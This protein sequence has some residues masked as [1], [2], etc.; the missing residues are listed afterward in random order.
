MTEAVLER[1]EKTKDTRIC[2]ISGPEFNGVQ[3]S[4]DRQNASTPH[5]TKLLM[6]HGIGRH[7]AGYSARFRDKL[8]QSLELD[9]MD[10]TIKKIALTDAPANG[11]ATGIL[12]IYR[13][14]SQQTGR[15]LLFYE[16]TWSGITDDEKDVVAFDNSEAYT[17]RRADINKSLKQFLNNTVP[18][19][20]VY[21][22]NKK[23]LIDQS[24]SQSVCWMFSDGWEKLPE[25]GSHHCNFY[26]NSIADTVINDDFFVVTHSM[27]SRITIDTFNNLALS[28]ETCTACDKAKKVTQALQNKTITIFMLANQLPLLQVGKNEPL[29]TGLSAQYC[30][31]GG[32]SYNERLIGKTRIVAFNDPKDILSYSL[33]PDYARDYIDSRTCP[34]IINIDINIAKP[35]EVFGLA[36]FANPLNAHIGYHED[37]RVIDLIANG[38]NRDNMS[39]IIQNRCRWTE[40]TDGKK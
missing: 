29:Q 30:A 19:L 32:A 31:A 39:P 7:V 9:S 18:D 24:I 28:R 16:L 15:E 20:F 37:A 23:P 25:Q 27:G 34:E 33:P 4:M 35:T 38:L 26:D 8:V 17:Y 1:T 5:H 2:E 12:Q 22:G 21:E 13:H 6:V 40:Y 14:F 36:N 11:N 10:P 3:A